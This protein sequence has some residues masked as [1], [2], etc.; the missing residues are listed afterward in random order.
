MKPDF[1]H[2]LRCPACGNTGLDM[3]TAEKDSLEIRAGRLSC[4]ACN[5]SFNIKEGVINLLF[6]PPG[7]II[8]QQETICKA[9]L[10]ADGE[11][12]GFAVNRENIG[13][14]RGAFLSLPEGDGSAVFEKGAFR[15]VSD[16]SGRYIGFTE[17]L[18]LTGKEKLLELGADSCWSVNRFAKLGCDCVAL[19]ICHHL[20]VSDLYIRENNV[21]FERVIADMGN[22]PFR[23]GAFDIVFCS[24]SLHHT[25]DMGKTLREIQRV[26]KPGGRLAL[27][28]EPV[29]GSLF[30]WQKN[31]FGFKA[32]KL[33]LHERIYTL[34]EWLG[35]LRA[36]G[37]EPELYFSFF[38][39]SKIM[40][41]CFF[42]FKNTIIKQI[43][44]K[45]R[46]YP[47]LV[48]KPY[49]VDIVAYKEAPGQNRRKTWKSYII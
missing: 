8:S 20:I 9:D 32:K 39:K 22:L 16:L 33:G 12:G 31:I 29:L 10:D 17:R 23:D 4:R 47:L 5:N 36:A 13:K 6:D 43:L 30:S 42:L 27:F 45:S 38:Q 7:E 41:N 28:S 26:L 21:Y 11:G 37:L 40:G 14:H 34:A 18:K 3:D 49:K 25:L 48:M 35:Y 19:D 2:V 15:N 24:L 46:L 1:L 44:L